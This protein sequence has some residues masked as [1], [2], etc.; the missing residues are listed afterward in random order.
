MNLGDDNTSTVGA[1]TR[2]ST[3][4]VQGAA[5][6]STL[7]MA[8]VGSAYVAVFGVQGDATTLSCVSNQIGAEGGQAARLAHGETLTFEEASAAFMPFVGCAP[9]ADF[10]AGVV[11]TVMQLF[12]QQA[13]VACIEDNATALGTADRAA[14]L[15]LAITD[16]STFA[17]RLTE[18]FVPC[19]F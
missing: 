2:S 13:D 19:S 11:P 1:G 7:T 14:A 17:Q 3:T 18:Y 6:N 10:D 16:P 5:G 8:E 15:A 12:G 9:D 4:V